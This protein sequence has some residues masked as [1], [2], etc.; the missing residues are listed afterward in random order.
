MADLGIP[1]GFSQ[2]PVFHAVVQS[3]PGLFNLAD[4]VRC[5][6]QLV[7]LALEADPPC[8]GTSGREAARRALYIPHGLGNLVGLTKALSAKA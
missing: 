7:Q 2:V 4:L 5:E 8:A 6:L 1:Q 3:D